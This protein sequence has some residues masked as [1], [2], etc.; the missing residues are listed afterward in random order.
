MRTLTADEICAR[1]AAEDL[2]PNLP[3]KAVT[4]TGGIAE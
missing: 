2:L 1:L 3:V 4:T